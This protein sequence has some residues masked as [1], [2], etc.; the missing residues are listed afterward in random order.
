MRVE[1]PDYLE[2]L[3]LWRDKRLIKVISGVRRCGKSV[4]MAMY[5][6]WLRSQG[7]SSERI[8]S[9]N[10][11]DMDFE[12]LCQPSSLHAYVKERLKP[13]G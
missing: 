10:L 2:R 7:V 11:E 3:R 1:R 5:A 12:A 6:D 13:G 8:I 4:L 9:V